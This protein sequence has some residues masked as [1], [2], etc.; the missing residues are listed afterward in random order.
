[1]SQR[2][3]SRVQVSQRVRGVYFIDFLLSKVNEVKRTQ[4]LGFYVFVWDELQNSFCHKC[5]KQRQ[6]SVEKLLQNKV[7]FG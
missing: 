1:M 2:Q 4:K 3:I 7:I 5:S 6:K